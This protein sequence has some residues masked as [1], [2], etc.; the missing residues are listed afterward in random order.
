MDFYSKN[1]ALS[2]AFPSPRI[3]GKYTGKAPIDIAAIPPLNFD[4]DKI[5]ASEIKRLASKKEDSNELM[6]KFLIYQPFRELR[7]DLVNPGQYTYTL[8]QL[9]GLGFPEWKSNSCFCDV[10][11]VAC[12]LVSKFY[13]AQIFKFED[14][15]WKLKHSLGYTGL[16]SIDNFVK[17]FEEYRNFKGSANRMHQVKSFIEDKNP[18]SNQIQIASWRREGKFDPSD[19]GPA[20]GVYEFILDHFRLSYLKIPFQQRNLITKNIFKIGIFS[21]IPVYRITYGLIEDFKRQYFSINTDKIYDVVY[22]IFKLPP[23]FAMSKADVA[24]DAMIKFSK[25]DV[26]DPVILEVQDEIFILK[27][28][29]I[30]RSGHYV[31]VF[32]MDDKWVYFNASSEYKII[33][34]ANSRLVYDIEGDFRDLINSKGEMFLFERMQ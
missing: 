10:V 19:F 18:Q 6:G 31:L 11:F 2:A 16:Q 17:I 28:V 13:T 5:L 25:E 23:A 8:D 1:L 21:I 9:K 30:N 14:Y 4:S 24:Q 27:S 22:T 26:N 7:D 32:Y 3:Y 20:Q 33:E 29:V 34:Y 12:F 15:P